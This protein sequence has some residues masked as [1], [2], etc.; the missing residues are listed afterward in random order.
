[1]NVRGDSSTVDPGIENAYI[2]RTNY[3]ITVS[4]T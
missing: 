2:T 4:T 3:D 1:M